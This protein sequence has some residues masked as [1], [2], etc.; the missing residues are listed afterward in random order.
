MKGKR[1]AAVIIGCGLFIAAATGAMAGSDGSGQTVDPA[2]VQEMQERILN[3]PGIMAIILSLQND[4]DLQAL[5]KQA[6]SLVE[7]TQVEIAFAHV[8]ER[9]GDVSP[10]QIVSVATA[11]IPFLENDD[12]NRALM[13]SNMQRQAVP[14]LITEPP[15]VATGMEVEAARNSSM[16]IRDRNGLDQAHLHDGDACLL[17]LPPLVRVVREQPDAAECDELDHRC[18][19]VDEST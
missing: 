8:R 6:L 18:S 2:R 7:A 9:N 5:L 4:P 17:E 14:L 12:A 1:V 11:L 3:D 13:G 16:P 10:K 15:L 19:E